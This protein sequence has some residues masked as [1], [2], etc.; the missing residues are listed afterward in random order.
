MLNQRARERALLEGIADALLLCLAFTLAYVVRSNL[1]LP[2][3]NAPESAI[4]LIS[5][6]WLLFMSVP[7]FW[8]LSAQAKL[9]SEPRPDGYFALLLAISRPLVYL[10]LASGTAI[11]LFQA[12]TFS[13][14]VFFLFLLFTAV[15]VVSGKLLLRV[16]S[17]RS[18][19]GIYRRNILIVGINE[20]ATRIR[21][22]IEC[23]AHLGLTVVGQ[24][25]GPGEERLEEALGTATDLKRIV[26]QRV[27]DDVVVALPF[28]Q[29][30]E[31][32]QA[33]AWCEEVG[34]SVHLKVDFVRTLFART[35]PSSLDGIPMLTFSSIPHDTP[36]LIVKRAIDLVGALAGLLTALPLLV[37]CGAIVKLT[38]KGPVLFTQERV[39]L[40][41]R[42]FRLYKFR[43]M[44]RDA[45]DRKPHL[46]SSN[47]M[48]GPVFKM[49]NDPRV[50][51]VGRIMRRYSLDEL[52]QLWNVLNGDMSLVGPRPPIPAEVHRYERWQRRRLSMKPGL[53][54]L[55]QINGRNQI[56]N[57]EEWMR[58]DL[59]YI[60]TWSL[61][62]D[63]KILLQTVPVVL[64]AKGAQ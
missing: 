21:S 50:T 56:T 20:E 25:S 35:Y 38:S 48:G 18:R 39:G 5:H 30:R 32:E 17:H 6:V 55:W 64:L 16:I 53:T 22:K 44:Y 28:E 3:F 29:L 27:V 11:F 58:L 1:H 7:L 33:I 61:K 41:G 36:S 13:R 2:F 23:Q 8:L 49:K 57:F 15:F 63:L 4:D 60:D 40:N 45:E 54:C 46:Q 37:L 42:L 14:A 62:L 26:E 12:K 19:S 31:Y 51:P 24:L 47:E 10:A 34:V 59:R 52:P 43:S 9:Y